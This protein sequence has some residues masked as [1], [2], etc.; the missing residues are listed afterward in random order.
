MAVEWLTAREMRAWRA[1]IEVQGDLINA[2]ERDLALAALQ[3]VER[4]LG[5]GG[6]H[7]AAGAAASELGAVLESV[8]VDDDG[9]AENAHNKHVINEDHLPKR[10]KGGEERE[11]CRMSVFVFD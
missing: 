4:T 9:R 8:V 2:I 7:E 1:Y 11:V 3:R 6:V 10:G 5:V